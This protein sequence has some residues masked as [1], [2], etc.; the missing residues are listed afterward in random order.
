M[1][2]YSK[3]IL[4]FCLP[5]NDIEYISNL[6]LAALRATVDEIPFLAG[7]VVPFSQDQPWLRDI[8]PDGATYL[9]VKDL[10]QELSFSELQKSCFSS[11]L[12]DSDKLCPF[13]KSSYVRDDPVDVCRIRAN[14]ID[15]GLLLV[16]QVIHTVF[17]GRGITEFL[18]VFADKV[19]KAQRG[20]LT[21]HATQNGEGPP[22]MYSFDRNSVLSGGG[23][24]GS[25][26]KHPCWTAAPSKTH[27]KFSDTISIC[28]NFHISSDSLRALKEAAS[29]SLS[30]SDVGL[31]NSQP[32]S[33]SEKVT[34]ISTHDAI[35]ALIWRSILLARSRAGIISNNTLSQFCQA[36]DCRSRM[37]LPQPYHG[38]AFYGILTS[39]DITQFA[40]PSD[41]PDTSRIP[42]L[43]AAA[44]AIRS[45]LMDAT[46][47]KFRDLL[48]FVERTEKDFLTRFTVVE[49]L[50]LKSMFLISYFGFEMHELDFGDA[51]G[52]H[53]AAFR[54]PSQGIAPGMPIVLPRLPDGS[55]EFIINE[56]EEV[57]RRLAEDKVFAKFARRQA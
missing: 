22:H 9:E 43:Q 42:G 12:L 17:D 25:I 8:R 21:K 51:L 47:E 52:G 29:P 41:A 44:R 16:V 30:P 53:I 50:Q 24:Y 20:E 3:R 54:V 26:E 28:A 38:N 36:I 10:S 37:G 35:A 15:G 40:P 2:L 55:C 27:G 19:R 5:N 48:G 11:S 13:P 34:Y 49:S 33:S 46:A 6:L 23:V 45:E 32:H 56:Q 39:L 31:P 7:S 57:M 4:C 1:P 14:F 18:K